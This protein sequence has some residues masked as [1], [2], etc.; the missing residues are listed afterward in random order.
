MIEWPR[1]GELIAQ[2]RTDPDLDEPTRAAALLIAEQLTDQP[3]PARLLDATWR[4][5]ETS[6][7]DPR[8]Y[9]RALLWA[10]EALRF[11]AAPDGPT[12]TNLGFAYYRV[13]R[14]AEAWD[15]FNRAEPMALD[16]YPGFAPVREVYRMMILHRQGHRAEARSRLDQF[17]RQFQEGLPHYFWSGPLLRE[18]EALIDPKLV[19]NRG[20]ATADPPR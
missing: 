17:R 12:L 9:Q 3:Q 8:D 20:Q 7:R 10:E 13:G 19:G 1:K 4:I 11:S 15:T 14:L 18:A 5:L 16:T 2:L 6:H